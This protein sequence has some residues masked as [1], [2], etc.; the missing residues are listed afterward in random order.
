[1]PAMGTKSREVIW[2]GRIGAAKINAEGARQRLN[3]DVRSRGQPGL[4]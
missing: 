2:S 3:D 1:M 4:A